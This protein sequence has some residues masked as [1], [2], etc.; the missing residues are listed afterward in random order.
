MLPSLLP[1]AII[2]LSGE[3]AF[4]MSLFH[5]SQHEACIAVPL[6]HRAIVRLRTTHIMFVVVQEDDLKSHSP[7]HHAQI[8][9]LELVILDC[10]WCGASSVVAVGF[11]KSL[12]VT[13]ICIFWL[14]RYF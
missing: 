4:K 3:S 6:A 7:V 9:G 1:H 14:K 12:L 2:L 10:A 8:R 11:Q 13:A 5:G